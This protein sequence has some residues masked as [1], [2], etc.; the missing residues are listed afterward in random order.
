MVVLVPLPPAVGRA[1]ERAIDQRT[2]GGRDRFSRPA[3][4]PGWTGTV[5]AVPELVRSF[6]V[7]VAPYRDAPVRRAAASR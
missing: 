5:P 2:A 4:A 7:Y 1:I 3:A 6:A